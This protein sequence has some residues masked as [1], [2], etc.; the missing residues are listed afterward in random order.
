[1]KRLVWLASACLSIGLLASGLMVASHSQAQRDAPLALLATIEVGGSPDAIVVNCWVGRNDVIF[2]DRSSGGK[3]RFIDG[4]T[5]TLAP[6]EISLPTREWEGWMVYDK[7]HHQA[8]VLS[9]QLR[10]TPYTSWEEVRVHV[11][12]WRSRLGSFSV[13]DVYNTDP[14]NPADKR[15]GIDGLAFKQPM[16]E[17]DNPGRLI[18]DNT[19]EGN[20]DV[21][22]FNTTG[23]GAARLQRYSYR[24]PVSSS[25]WET[26]LGN[27]LALETQYETLTVDDLTSTDVLYISDKNHQDDYGLRALQL[28]HPLQDLNVV[29]LPDVDLQQGNCGIGGCQGIA[30]AGSRDILYVASGNQSFESG[31]VNEVDTTDN[32][33]AQ[34]VNLTYGDLYEVQVDWYDP[35]RAFV[36]TFDHYYNDPHQGLYLHLIYDGTVVDTLRVMDNYE[37]DDLRGMAFDPYHRRLYLTVGSSVMVVQVNYGAEPPPLPPPPPVIAWTA[38]GPPWYGGTLDT[39]DGSAHLDFYPNAVSQTTVV[40]Y[41]TDVS[42]EPTG[43]LFGVRFFDLSATFSDTGAPA[44]FN[45]SYR[46]VINYTDAEKGAAIESTL[47]LYWWDGGQWV[48]EPT[49][50]VDAAAN[51]LTATPDHMTLFAVL[52]ETRRVYLPIV[53]RNW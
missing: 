50:S 46:I 5:L 51:R 2:Y 32:Q 8:Y 27:S 38:I 3:V 9:T 52:G 33:V 22:D 6:E 41:T 23:T 44:V 40:T 31:Y 15:Y 18:I 35:K 1:M 16:S 10:W 30:M 53:M 25:W 24:D 29:P 11:V 7:Y 47:G 37:E 28:N 12:A 4:D 19:A 45:H 36:A 13:N 21:V 26:N 14:Q 39:P 34:V 20:I 17:G 49:S 48:L 43:D 42:Q